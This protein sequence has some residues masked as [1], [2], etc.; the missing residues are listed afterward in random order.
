MSAYAP[1]YCVLWTM[2]FSLFEILR[3]TIAIV[4]FFKL[5]CKAVKEPY[6]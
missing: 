6:P 3:A 4:S 5:M 2:Y 1:M